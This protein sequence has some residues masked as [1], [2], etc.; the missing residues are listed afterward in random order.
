MCVVCKVGQMHDWN[1]VVYDGVYDKK[2]PY[3]PQC[4]LRVTGTEA[5]PV[6]LNIAKEDLRFAQGAD[7]DNSQGLYLIERLADGSC[8]L[9]QSSG[10]MSRREI[11]MEVTLQ[12]GRTYELAC[13]SFMGNLKFRYVN[14][15]V[16]VFIILIACLYDA[17][18]SRIGCR[19]SRSS[20]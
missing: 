3:G 14:A 16:F 2:E 8:Q 11:S 20:R 10:D 18:R 1:V 6:L 4:V 7:K 5:T 19:S 17:A 12:P 15:L 9:V 13:L